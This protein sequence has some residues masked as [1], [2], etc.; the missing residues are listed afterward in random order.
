[1][2]K[3]THIND[4]DSIN[5]DL[6]NDLETVCTEKKTGNMFTKLL[7]GE[8]FKKPTYSKLKSLFIRVEAF[9]LELKHIFEKVQIEKYMSE[10]ID[11]EQ[12]K[13]IFKAKGLGKI[14]PNFNIDRLKE[15]YDEPPISLKSP[16]YQKHIQFDKIVIRKYLIAINQMVFNQMDLVVVFAGSEGCGKCCS[17]CAIINHNNTFLT[18]GEFDELEK[19]KN[20]E[21]DIL[22]ENQEFEKATWFKEETNK[23]FKITLEDGTELEGTPEHKIKVLDVEKGIVWRKLEHIKEDDT[24]L[25]SYD[26]NIFP[27]ENKQF[28]FN[29]I[30]KRHD[31]HS[32]NIKIPKEMNENIGYLM[33]CIIANGNILKDSNEMLISSTNMWINNNLFDIIKKEFGVEFKYKYDS[34]KCVGLRKSNVKLAE[35]IKTQIGYGGETA[36][37]KTIPLSIR[38]STKEVQLSFIQGLLDCD[39]YFHGYGIEYSTAS[40]DLCFMTRTLLMNLGIYCTIRSKYLKQYDH[41]YWTVNIPK[42]FSIKLLNM[43]KDKK[44]KNEDILV[45]LNKKSNSNVQRIN[46]D[47]KNHIRTILEK[48][49]YTRSG[50]VKI[51]NKFVRVCHKYSKLKENHITT[52]DKI[53]SL[54]NENGNIPELESFLDYV[55]DNNIICKKVK[56]KEL[57]TKT[58]NVYDFTIPTNHTFICNS[59][60]N[61][62]TTAST[63]DSYLIYYLLN[64]L[65]LVEYEYNLKNIMYYNLKSIV[66][67]FNKFSRTPFRLFVM[68]EGNELN[69]KSWANPLVELFFQHLRRGRKHLRIIII[70]L[71][72]IGELM[73]SITLSR[74]NFIFQLEMKMNMQTKLA[75]KGSTKMFII[76]RGNKIYSYLNKKELSQAD[77]KNNLGKILDDKK[78]YFQLLPNYLCVHQFKRNGVWSFNEQ[79]YD[80][81]SKDAN[82]AFSTASVSLTKSEIFHLGKFFDLKK[83]GVKP[84]TQAYHTLAHLKNKKLKVA[85]K[86][87]EFENF[88]NDEEAE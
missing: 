5:P 55:K 28:N 76:P 61:H 67:A 38:Q 2:K 57:I 40:K 68:D 79:A 75:D 84:G 78:K 83:M 35:F 60:I 72:Q 59:L 36:R 11:T 62:N 18:F 14:Y 9:Y 50:L 6:I 69:R 47:F 49:Y 34:V 12:L 17:E 1:M 81:L 42:L 7:S 58:Q 44:Y 39:S 30:K 23:T 8:Y 66:Q 71:P 32:T 43:F 10:T 74:V 15:L 73:P 27:K 82:D 54:L 85:L 87:D 37:L 21:F 52:F 25:I 70:N 29:Y 41:T 4:D 77:V 53:D 22:S 51:D 86:N 56:T 46:N 63:Q 64:E 31:S 45:E 20:K 13:E 26:T 80:K 88:G 24:C 48:N 65:G 3:Q 33:G 16:A 19:D